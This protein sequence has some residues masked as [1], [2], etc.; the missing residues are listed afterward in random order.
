MFAGGDIF[1][2]W[3]TYGL[4][5]EAVTAKKVG[6]NDV[7]APVVNL[8]TI[9]KFQLDSFF[10]KVWQ[11][12]GDHFD[13]VDLKYQ[14][15]DG[16][17]QSV[18]GGWKQDLDGNNREWG[19]KVDKDIVADLADGDHSLQLWFV[20]ELNP[21]S[22]EKKMDNLDH[23]N[24]KF[25][26]KKGTPEPKVT[27]W[28]IRGSFNEWGA[29]YELTG[30]DNAKKVKITV[31]AK[32][33]YEF[34]FIKVVSQ[35]TEKDTTWF[36]LAEAGHVM[37]YG[38]CTDW[39]AYQTI[40][41]Q[42]KNAANVGLLST[43]AGDY[44]FTVDVTNK[45]GEEI[46]PKFNV[47]IPE[48]DP[49]DVK[50][51]VIGSFN[52]WASGF[53]L[54]GEDNAKK[55]KVT[56]E[57]KKNYEFKLIRVE[58][59]DTT[60]FGLPEAGHVME[61]GACADWVAYKTVPEENKNEANVGLKTTKAGDYEFTV[62]VT[63]KAGEEIA[64]KFS[65]AIPEPDP[66]DV[67]WFVIGSFNAWASGFELAGEDNA[68]KVKVTVEAK[69]NY[70]FKF[71]RVEDNDTT[72]FGLAE[73]GHVMKY[74]ECTDWIAYQ[75]IA[76]QDKNAANV[77]LLST[78]A[79]DYEFTV[80][81]TNKA[82]EEIAPKF[83][84]AIPEPDPADLKWFV[85]GSFNEWA[86]G[87]ELTGEDN[88]KKVEV[89]VEAKK[90]YEFKFIR[91]EDNDTTWFGLAEAGHVM[92]YGEC[93]DWIAYQTIA[94][95]D[96]NAANVGLLST[97]AGNYEFTVDVTNKAGEEIAPKFSVAIPEPDPADVKW[98][99][100][101]T[102][103]D[104]KSG[105]E[106]EK[107]EDD[108]YQALLELEAK[109]NYE[110]KLIR[111]EDNDTV[112]FGLPSEGNVMKYGA[113]T[114]WKAYKSEGDQNQ[115]NI[116]LLTTKA[117][118]YPFTLDPNHKEGDV[119]APQFSFV[120]PEPE[121]STAAWFIMGNFNDWASGVELKGSVNAL[122]AKLT[123]E[124]NLKYE[125]KFISVENNDTVWYGL[126]SEGNV[127]KYGASTDWVAY[128]SEGELNQANVGLLA[129]KAGDYPFTVD[130]TNLDNGNIAPKFSVVIP[131]PEVS[132]ATWFVIGS[133]NDWAA[134][135][136]LTGEANA[137][138]AKIKVAAKAYYEFKLINVE[139]G[140]TTWY[141]LPSE[142]NIMKYGACT[143]WLAFKSEGDQNQ[144]N[145]GLQTTEAGDYIFTVDPTNKAEGDILAPKFSVAIPQGDD[146]G[147]SWFIKLPFAQD[148]WNWHPMTEEEDGTWSY[149]DKW[150]GG[151]ANVNT[152]MDDATA[153]YIKD[154]EMDFGDNQVAPEQ[155][156]ECTFIWNAT[157]QVLSVK[158][159][160]SE[161]IE[162]VVYE[163]DTNAPMYN[164][165]GVEV[166]ADFKGIVIQNGHKFIR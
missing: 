88:A 8:G 63:N 149:S 29:G 145:V 28:Y 30:E 16:A 53:E 15:D 163:L 158:Y 60:W 1:E 141:G 106:V 72:W 7:Q 105:F 41:D 58:D 156:T 48:P 84:V 11:D 76:D 148:D 21:G 150:F 37:K 136:P 25:N 135:F 74:G 151:G 62:D 67:K 153:K 82:G 43:K 13:K 117:G 146:P 24:Y 3:V 115:A 90:N 34:K 85:I 95:Q 65:V 125:F 47:A 107:T 14:I 39:I 138:Q 69:K 52:E 54:A 110:F 59:N 32:K 71:I 113:C 164:I 20:G 12:N 78:K 147:L 132:D 116:G 77:G 99:I 83:S 27:N 22:Q 118:H 38:E 79:G 162:N 86:S 51:F 31:E 80:D 134:G 10:V 143:D 131:E 122:E 61:Y 140:D 94:D 56:V 103:N 166:D 127:M 75:T 112:W 108:T 36:G 5:G 96:K 154:E 26:F 139:A 70:E 73:A 144:A 165:M 152:S 44:E 17:V 4:N 100:I 81:V 111:V 119:L 142:G 98:F 109:K 19:I 160:K 45:A 120:I 93:T 92:K 130:V 129:T 2:A 6:N 49:A 50:W 114:D 33:N 18:E 157:T 23:S 159:E 123:L 40:A 121:P 55:V 35:G 126:P 104:W 66:A 91:V 97:K 102:F 42:D 101:G 87:F 124:A 133:F 64:P 89:A 161:G 155:G 128:K 137:L 68:K 57:A 46:A 9:N